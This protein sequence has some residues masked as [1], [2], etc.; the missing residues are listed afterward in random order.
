[1]SV[2]SASISSVKWLIA[3]VSAAKNSAA[4]D[5]E[6]SEHLYQWMVLI[7]RG[8]L[9]LRKALVEHQQSCTKHHRDIFRCETVSCYL[10]G[11]CFDSYFK[12]T[13]FKEDDLNTLLTTIP[14]QD[15]NQEHLFACLSERVKLRELSDAQ[16][17]GLKE[18]LARYIRDADKK[19]LSN[20]E[21]AEYINFAAYFFTLNKER[22]IAILKAYLR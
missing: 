6:V 4:F 19:E 7:K 10:Q 3:G 17:Q 18:R 5:Q 11:P 16:Q 21:I 20:I 22:S 14:A 8:R 2:I 1:M 12:N 13:N 15:D 9:A